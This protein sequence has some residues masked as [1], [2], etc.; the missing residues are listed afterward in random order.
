[1]GERFGIDVSSHQGA[2]AWDEV[3]ADGIEFVYI[4]ASEGQAWVDASFDRNWDGAAQAGLERGAYHFFTL[5]AAGEEQAR[6]FLTVAPP[7]ADTLPPAVDVE[8][9]GNCSARPPAAEVAAELDVF[10]DIV[11]QAWGEDVL[12][13]V[14][15]QWDEHYPVK[16]RPARDIWQPS[17]LVRPDGAWAIW[18]LH[19][20][21]N[22]DGIDGGVDLDVMSGGT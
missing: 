9:P 21:A 10:I 20:W 22:V 6:N 5:C 17:F 19:G 11:E 13:Y 18:Q 1:V 14:G 15:R 4:K 12:V 3:A 2:I 7:E 8:F 16:D